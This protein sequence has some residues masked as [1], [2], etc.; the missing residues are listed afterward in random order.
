[1]RIM[2]GIAMMAGLSSIQQVPDKLEKL[3]GFRGFRDMGIKAIF[4][5]FADGVRVVIAAQ[6]HEPDVLIG[7]VLPDLH[8]GMETIE[9][10]KPEIHD[11]ELRTAQHGGLD[12]LLAVV[13]DGNIET[14]RFEE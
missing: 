3:I 8:A 12:G 2:G 14:V 7:V 13:G 10:G 11:H 9:L 6:S 5:T 4:Q 1:M